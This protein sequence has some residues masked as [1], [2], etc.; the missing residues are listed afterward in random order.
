MSQ[1]LSDNFQEKYFGIVDLAKKLQQVKDFYSYKA[2]EKLYAQ[3]YCSEC[4]R[5]YTL[6]VD[7]EKCRV[8]G[9]EQTPSA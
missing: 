1:V 8:C 9:G 3:F 6:P 4:D 5:E 7:I 2:Q